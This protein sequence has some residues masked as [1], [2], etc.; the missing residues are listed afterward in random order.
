MYFSVSLID[1]RINR[2]CGLH[3]TDYPV[4]LK[5]IDPYIT[6]TVNLLIKLIG[7]YFFI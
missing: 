3:S 5:K 2:I 6:H 4:A 1:S 7:Y